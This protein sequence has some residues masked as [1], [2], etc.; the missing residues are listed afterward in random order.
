VA[1]VAVVVAVQRDKLVEQVRPVKDLR[2][3][4]QGLTLIHIAAQVAV[5]PAQSEQTATQEL[6]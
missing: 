4:S 1:E 5:E 3:V 6:A 2:E